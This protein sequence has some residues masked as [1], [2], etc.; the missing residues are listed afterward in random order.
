MI[1]EKFIHSINHHEFTF[2]LV[3]RKSKD[4]IVA[5][6]KTRD[7]ILKYLALPS[8]QNTLSLKQLSLRSKP[9]M[10]YHDAIAIEAL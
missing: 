6:V 7:I 4:N 10:I 3:Y 8:N 2:V 1:D 5:Y 9:H